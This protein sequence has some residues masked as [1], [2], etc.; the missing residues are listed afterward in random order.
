M[1]NKVLMT[2]YCSQHAETLT[3]VTVEQKVLSEDMKPKLLVKLGMK[4]AGCLR[5][6]AGVPH[7]TVI[8]VGE[9]RVIDLL[10][11]NHEFAELGHQYLTVGHNQ[12]TKS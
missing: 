1:Q 8:A 6:G 10:V 7:S 2:W 11:V 12:V 5:T 9:L 4:A 3:L